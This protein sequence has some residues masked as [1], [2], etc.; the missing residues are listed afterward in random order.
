MMWLMTDGKNTE[1]WSQ[2]SFAGCPGGETETAT[3][4][5]GRFG[6]VYTCVSRCFGKVWLVGERDRDPTCRY[7]AP[8]GETHYVHARELF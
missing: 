8:A 1:Q 3:N 4:V 5:L 7:S 6:Y 2:G